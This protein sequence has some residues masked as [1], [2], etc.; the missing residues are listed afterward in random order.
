MSTACSNGGKSLRIGAG[1]PTTSIS[2]TSQDLILMPVDGWF[3]PDQRLTVHP[4]VKMRALRSPAMH[5]R[6]GSL[7]SGRVCGITV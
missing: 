5:E 6:P 1:I 7:Q 2:I 4:Y 3:G